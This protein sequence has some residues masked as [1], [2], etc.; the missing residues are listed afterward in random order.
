MYVD[1]LV[2]LKNKQVDQ[3]YTY[4]VPFGLQ[5]EIAIGKRVKVSFNH[6]PLEGFIL[7]IK[8]K[9]EEDR[10]FLQVEEVIV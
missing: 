10:K 1:V 5:E 7:R 4:E 3:T 8:D 6:R 2:E 9:I